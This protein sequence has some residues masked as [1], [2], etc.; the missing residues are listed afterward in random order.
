MET[1][2]ISGFHLDKLK[3]LPSAFALWRRNLNTGQLNYVHLCKLVFRSSL[4]FLKIALQKLAKVQSNCFTFT[5]SI[6]V[7]IGLFLSHFV[8]FCTM[9]FLWNACYHSDYLFE[10]NTHCYFSM[11]Y[12]ETGNIYRQSLVKITNY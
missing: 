10:A 8:R 11:K 3:S 9:E 2:K 6:V 5:S 4:I 1:T 7:Y 12:W